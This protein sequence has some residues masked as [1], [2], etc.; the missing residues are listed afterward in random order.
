MIWNVVKFK[1]KIE[2]YLIRIMKSYEI[3]IVDRNFNFSLEKL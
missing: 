1:V 3:K 2:N